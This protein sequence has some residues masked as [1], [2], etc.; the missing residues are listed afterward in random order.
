MRGQQ[1]KAIDV[2]AILAC[3]VLAA[4]FVLLI[5]TPFLGGL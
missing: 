5:A 3:S 4:P 1:I 2:L